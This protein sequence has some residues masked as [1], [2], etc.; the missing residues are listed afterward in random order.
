MKAIGREAQ[1]FAQESVNTARQNPPTLNGNDL[2]INL[3]NGSSISF[4]KDELG[5]QSDVVTKKWTPDDIEAL[6]GLFNGSDDEGIEKGNAAK[7]MLF[8]DS[9]SVEGQ[10]HE[11][12]VENSNRVTPDFAKDKIILEAEKIL[13]EF[14]KEDIN[15]CKTNKFFTEKEQTVHQPMLEQCEQVIDRSGE[16]VVTHDY[17]A[18]VIRH[19]DGAFNF[20]SCGEGCAEMWLS[21]PFTG[22]GNSGKYC[23][24]HQFELK[25]QIIN[26]KAITKATISDI[27][28]DDQMQLFLGPVGN[29]R[30]ILQLPYADNFV[31]EYFLKPDE[32][33]EFVYPG[34]FSGANPQSCEQRKAWYWR[35]T[36]LDITDH[37][38]TAKKDDIY[39]FNMR[40]AIAGNIGGAYAKLRVYYDPAQ[41]IVDDAWTPPTCV[42]NTYAIDDGFAKGTYECIDMPRVGTDGC[43]E[44]D[45][46]FVCP[47]HLGEAPIKGINNLCRKVLVKSQYDFYKGSMDCW[48][49]IHGVEQCPTN[50]GGML[51]KCEKLVDKGCQFISS[52]CTDGALGASGTC[53]VN[54]VTYDCGKD[55]VIKDTEAKEEVVCNGDIGCRGKDCLSITETKSDSFGKVTAMMNSLQYMAKDMTCTGVDENDHQTGEEDV[56][57]TV[58]SGNASTCKIAVGGIQDCCENPA[59][60]GMKPFLGL[61]MT[62]ATGEFTQG[63]YGANEGSWEGAAGEA[64]GHGAW[65]STIA[66]V[67]Q[68]SW[69]VAGYLNQFTAYA[70]NINSWKDIYA[71]SMKV[72]IA[73]SKTTLELYI[74]QQLM[75]LFSQAGEA[76]GELIGSSTAGAA[77]QAGSGASSA[78]MGAAGAA[79]GVIAA[80]YAAYVLAVMI[81]QAVYQCTEEEM[82]LTAMRDVGNCTYLGSYCKKKRLG[83]CTKKL[84]SY[85]CFSSPLSR[86]IQQEL[87]KQGDRLGPGF[88][89]FG[90]AKY[91][92]CGG[93]PLEKIGDIDWDRVNLDEWIAILEMNGKLPN[94]NTVDVETLTGKASKFNFD[95]ERTNSV[96]RNKERIKHIDVDAERAKADREFEIDTGYRGGF[97]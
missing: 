96:D 90:S 66:S 34:P 88:N 64:A 35:N 17:S 57:C 95:G 32:R 28:W 46:V 41:A 63:S 29:E 79:L 43:A 51:D 80:V 33:P 31:P 67:G 25:F 85:C 76:I 5:N 87:R 42:Q 81:I 53:Y 83:F 1:N 11:M 23:K 56:K 92:S 24:L 2:T 6:K 68:Q 36:E 86:I 65:S 69:A 49:D 3:P 73:H 16:C 8:G 94:A 12:L 26:P 44:I 15:D 71:P 93:L 74:K 59:P 52:Q 37:L 9:T 38:T 50:N 47:R 40:V 97:H 75:N 10:V 20:K 77:G 7:E 48:T 78:V 70:E 18:G 91:P 61:I 21:R 27:Y 58:F 72:L 30:K 89:G 84:R 82:Q 4:N 55:V 14:Q 13:K 60:V 62:K 39:R 22:G 19:Y 45:G 54:D